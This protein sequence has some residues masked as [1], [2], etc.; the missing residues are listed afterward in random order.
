MECP[1][2]HGQ[3]PEGATYCQNCGAG[4]QGSFRPVNPNQTYQAPIEN[5]IPVERVNNSNNT[6]NRRVKKN[7]CSTLILI[8]VIVAIFI[9]IKMFSKNNEGNNNSNT[10]NTVSSDKYIE[11][12]EILDNDNAFL[13]YIEDSFDDYGKTVI[14]GKIKRGE[15]K[16]GDKIELITKDGEIKE[17]KVSKLSQ[18]RK[19]VSS[20]KSGDN[21]GIYIDDITTD[22]IE[23]GEAL[24]KI[25][26]IKPRKGIEA[27]IYFYTKDEGGT[28]NAITGKEKLNITIDSIGK[29]DCKL[30]LNETKAGET[31][32][33]F[34]E[35]DKY[36]ALEVGS[37]FI[38]R[39]DMKFVGNGKVT[40]VY[41]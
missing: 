16:T 40:K 13:M 20:A 12:T 41:K 17:V 8:L 28:E 33:T 31:L 5:E 21:I 35:L 3:V 25:N 34:I 32:T 10:N 30:S 39:D 38:L 36:M 22:D 2:C 29:V 9:G 26:S 14:T 11:D 7:N 6:N 27:E 37:D 4:I 19:E 23:E 1:Y 24:A 15:V 18:F